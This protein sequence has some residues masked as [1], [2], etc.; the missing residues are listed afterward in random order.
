M[1]STNAG[2][3]HRVVLA[4][5]TV[6]DTQQGQL[7]PAV[8]LI[9]ED[10]RIGQI[11]PSG[12]VPAGGSSTVIDAAGKFVVPGFLDMHAHILEEEHRENSLD[13]LLAHG[14]TGWRQMSGSPRLLEE[15]R[16]GTLGLAADAPELLE[17]PG[18]IL[19]P[20]NAGSPEASVA[21]VQRQKAAGANFIKTISVRPKTFFASL[22]AATQVGL[23]YAGHLSPGVDAAKASV[24]G[25]RSI[26]HLGPLELQLIHCSK[27]SWLIRLLLAVRP[28]AVPDLSPEKMA[29]TGRLIVASPTLFR[30]QMEPDGLKRTQRLI[31]TFSEA[32]CR[33]LAAIC[34]THQTWQVPTL[35]RIETMQLAE[36]TRFAQD[37]NLRYIAKSTRQF[38]VS[39]AQKFA[40]LV[41]PEGKQTLLRLTALSLRMTKIF[42]EC[43]V[44]MMTGS[45][46]GGIWVIPGV[47][48]HQEFDLLAQAGLSP[49]KILQ[50]ATLKPA[51][52][53]HRE[54]TL[55]SVQPGRQADLVLLD[56]D[57]TQSA[58]NL[59][60]IYAVV[61]AGR[62]RSR[63]ELDVLKQTVAD[64]IA[65]QPEPAP[66]V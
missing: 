11:V 1:S 4:G 14:I 42:D 37:P 18:S 19:T 63:K 23:P 30:M 43:G 24:A 57:P 54:A 29:T 48:L 25:M 62:Y 28:P 66:Q 33:K 52:F 12:S 61:R 26:E 39:V 41:T 22:Q 35:I 6:V 64:R 38:W 21:E 5:V 20:L 17:M 9:L 59:H 8:D 10:E 50:M 49:L 51:Q 3:Q 46:Y 7:T 34:A 15:R 44:A 55:G 36:E 60:S 45:D 40:A 13:L 58:A 31:D 56:A 27:L 65:S 47:S 32:K 53:L 2:T 16:Q